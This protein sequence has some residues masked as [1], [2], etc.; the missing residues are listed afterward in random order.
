MPPTRDSLG[1]EW[2]LE[3]LIR[4]TWQEHTRAFLGK[5]RPVRDQDLLP[6]G[7]GPH[8]DQSP[9]LNGGWLTGTKLLQ[10]FAE[11][12]VLI[13]LSVMQTAINLPF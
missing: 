11:L 5:R 9:R 6:A 8:G 13:P 2:I 4:L 7:T 12:T 10:G 3:L 1:P